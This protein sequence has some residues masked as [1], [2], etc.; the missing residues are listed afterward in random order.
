MSHAPNEK[1]LALAG[2]FQATRLV[3]KVAT[4]N[5]VDQAAFETC[6]N[7]IIE[8]DPTNTLAVYGGTTEGITLGLELL[9]EQFGEDITQRDMELT[10]YIVTI[11]HLTGKLI[12]NKMM[13]STLSNGI[14]RVRTQTAHYPITHE[15][16]IAG[17]AD[18][19]VNTISNIKPRIIVN[20][21]QGYLANPG[22]ANK[23]RA[24]LLA[25]IRSTILWRQ[26]GGTRLQLMFKR[27]F[28]AQTA[29]GFLYN[30][31]ASH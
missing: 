21:E 12:K 22:N 3:Q 2:V 31:P 20:G 4:T 19:Y 25:A 8:I 9:Q 7:S 1:I 30:T 17:I 23:V 5:N 15:N 6:L 28:I 14:G 18:I 10:K 16:V 29:R 27:K 24:L 13:L 11:V 26:C